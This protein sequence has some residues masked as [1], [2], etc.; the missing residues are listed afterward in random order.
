MMST[1]EARSRYL[2][3]GTSV[4]YHANICALCHRGVWCRTGAR[5]SHNA[6]AASIAYD[7]AV[8]QDVARRSVAWA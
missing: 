5:W 7:L 1:E 2:L 8:A 4:F 6:D 3:Y